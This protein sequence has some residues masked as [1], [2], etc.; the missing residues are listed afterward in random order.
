[1]P[2]RNEAQRK[3]AIGRSEAG[4]SQTAVARIF[5][6]CPRALSLDFGTDTSRMDQPVTCSFFVPFYVQICSPFLYLIVWLLHVF[7][8]IV[9]ITLSFHCIY[10]IS[11]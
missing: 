3:N 2:R 11:P 8:Q 10:L 4:E 5:N 1:M 7:F 9:E 6:I